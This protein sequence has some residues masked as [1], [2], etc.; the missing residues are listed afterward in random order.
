M[1]TP[2][3]ATTQQRSQSQT[4][5]P[6]LHRAVQLLQMSS[7]DFAQELSAVLGSNPFVDD[8]AADDMPLPS[9]LQALADPLGDSRADDAEDGAEAA[10]E[11]GAPASDA[12]EHKGSVVPCGEQTPDHS[13]HGVGRLGRTLVARRP[14]RSSDRQKREQAMERGRLG[15]RARQRHA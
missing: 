9:A 5:S 11:T 13:H 2:A 14:A 8:D 4:L 10:N 12:Q 7:L 15:V 1:L 6:R 3:L